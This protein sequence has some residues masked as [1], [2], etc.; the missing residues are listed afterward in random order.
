[1]N[2]LYDTKIRFGI[3]C[4][5]VWRSVVRAIQMT[6]V[7]SVN[8]A[9][10]EP[11][12][13]AEQVVAPAVIKQDR[14]NDKEARLAEIDRETDEIKKA[15]EVRTYYYH[16]EE[17]ACYKKFFVNACLEKNASAFKKDIAELRQREIKNNQALR[18]YEAQQR[19]FRKAMEAADLEAR[20]PEDAA[21]GAENRAAY[22]R[23]VEA[24]MQKQAE[25]N[26][27]QRQR[28][29]AENVRKFQQKQL[30][31]EQHR[32]AIKARQ[33]EKQNR[34]DKTEPAPPPSSGK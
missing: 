28:E 1:M 6:V 26:S 24:I 10:A 22:E 3:V 21:I 5:L 9:W 4:H 14:V 34:L 8:H 18:D 19:A 11:V 15:T 33:F 12:P 2:I 31:A 23:K 17:I 7:L 32:Q 13:V 16:L 20:R 30:E 27:E 25:V 29:R